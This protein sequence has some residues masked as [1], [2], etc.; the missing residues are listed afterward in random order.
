M[1]YSVRRFE[2]VDKYPLS[3]GLKRRDTLTLD[4]RYDNYNSMNLHNKIDR[5]SVLDEL[6]VENEM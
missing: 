4:G 3:W 6:K 1:I 5:S 2:R